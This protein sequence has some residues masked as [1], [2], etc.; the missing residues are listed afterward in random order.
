MYLSIEDGA[1]YKGVDLFKGVR[2]HDT[3]QP[4]YS[5]VRYSSHG[6]PAMSSRALYELYVC[7][8]LVAWQVRHHTYVLVAAST[9]PSDR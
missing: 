8:F 6:E 2:C 3:Q 5:E 1:A 9:K 7:P 4:Y